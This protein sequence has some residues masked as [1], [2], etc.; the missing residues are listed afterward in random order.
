[1][2]KINITSEDVEKVRDFL[3]PMEFTK[4][5][6][7]H[8]YRYWKYGGSTWNYYRQGGTYIMK[9]LMW[10]HHRNKPGS[11]EWRPTIIIKAILEEIKKGH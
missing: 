7:S 3:R 1:M 9:T 2:K 4:E 8:S 5:E 10:Y 11:K 6:Y